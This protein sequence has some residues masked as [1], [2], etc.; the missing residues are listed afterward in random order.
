[1]NRG[2]ASAFALLLAAA[3]MGRAAACFAQN[4]PAPL[5]NQPL[6][7]EAVAPGGNSFTLT[8]NGTGFVSGSAVNW[9]GAAL[10]TQFVSGSQLTAV[11][12]A[13]DVAVAGTATLTITNP[14]P[15]GGV[16]NPTTFDITTPTSSISFTV[17]AE[18]TTGSGVTSV[19]MGDFNGDGKL[20]LVTAS[21]FSGPD[22]VLLG[23]GDGTFHSV[24]AP[25]FGAGPMVVGDFNGDGKLDLAVANA[26]LS[27]TVS[28]WLGNGDGTFQPGVQYATG[29]L[30]LGLSAADFNGDGR[31][32]L[33]VVNEID[34]T[35]SALLG[36]GDGTFQPHVD[37]STGPDP[38]SVVVGDFNGDGKLDLA[39][40]SNNSTLG[41]LLGNGDGTFQ[42]QASYA[43]GSEPA[44]VV[45]AD[46]NGD[47]KLDLMTVNFGVLDYS[48]SVLLGNGDGT[49]QPHVDYPAGAEPAYVVTGDFNGDGKLDLAVADECG[50]PGIVSILLG[51]GDGTLGPPLSFD[52][53]SFFGGV[54]L[55]AGDFNGDGR[56]D[57]AVTFSNEFSLTVFLQNT[58]TL[59][60]TDLTFAAQNVGSM[61]TP[62]TVTLT[63]FGNKALNITSVA[64]A[65]ANPGDFG[66]TNSCGASVAVGASCDINVTFS[67]TATGTRTASVSV[68]DD[69]VGSPQ[70]VSLSG[71]GTA[72]AVTL[73]QT[74]L[75]FATQLVGTTSLAQRVTLTN[76]GDGLLTLSSIAVSGDYLERNTCGST[77]AAGASC[78]ITVQFRPKARGTRTGSVTITDNAAGS[79]QT[80]ALSGTGTVVS[81]SPTS[82]SF[83]TVKVGTTSP[84]QTVTVTNTAKNASLTFNGINVVGLDAPDFKQTNTCGASIAAGASCTVSVTFTPS[85]TGSRSATLSIG[86]S[87]GGSPQKAALQGTGS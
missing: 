9:N 14:A 83:G 28:I 41:V 61:S 40:D 51:N 81:V 27:N 84:P 87:G 74:S 38:N 16:S 25:F 78:T 77:V 58:A 43:T 12:P 35:V 67:P 68:T 48:V 46:L 19:A 18:Y 62:Q 10:A 23:N 49:F 21:P 4:N 59:S 6:V 11:I 71:T 50:V 20:D 3:V 2:R 44:W 80:I 56:A 37:Y 17:F 15:G 72:P 86:D 60:P 26:T 7:P 30:P 29:T 42:V 65:G 1:M 73:T 36:N 63:N 55:A 64:I 75:R 34:G 8:V 57:L 45:A 85:K 54:R 82:L 24:A 52:T 39:V 5:I 33:A 31:L 76:S 66:Q 47:G 69:G 32:D 22:L 70:T 53:N 79:P 13:T